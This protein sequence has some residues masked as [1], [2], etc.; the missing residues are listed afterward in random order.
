MTRLVLAV[1]LVACS[2]VSGCDRKIY[3]DG[4]LDAQDRF[5]AIELGAAE[6]DVRNALGTPSSVVVRAGS[7]ELLVEVTDG[8][9]TRRKPISTND[10]SNWPAELRFLS[11]RPVTSKV[12]VYIDGTVTAYYF[13]SPEGRLEYVDLFTS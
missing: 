6:Q 5:K 11:D 2:L 13:L 1:A 10:R 8:R 12:L 4:E 9:E 3:A 7:D